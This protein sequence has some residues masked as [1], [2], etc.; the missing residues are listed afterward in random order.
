MRRYGVGEHPRGTVTLLFTDIEGSTHLLQRV[1]ER[2]ADLLQTCRHLLRTTFHQYH[3]H[4]VDTQGDAFFVAFARATDAVLAAVG[5]QRALAVHAW[6]E[7]VTVSAR[8][9]LH[10]GEPLRTAEG[11]V[12]LDIHHASRIMSAGHG[13]QVLLSQT[14]CAM[15]EQSL[16]EGV[17]LRD[18]GEH[19]LKDLQRASHLYQL[20]IV[21]LPADFPPLKTLDASHH[22]LPIQLTPFLG[23][24]QVVATVQ[25]LLLREE[26]RLLT[27][28]GPGGTGKT[29]LGLQVTAE[30]SDRFSDGVHFVNLAPISDPELVVPTIAQTL[31]L[32]GTREQ[33]MLDMLQAYLA[34]EADLAAAGQLR[35]GGQCRRAGGRPAGCLSQA[36][37]AGDESHGAACAR[38][39]GVCRPAIGSTRPETPARTDGIDAV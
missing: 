37:G 19:R 36:Q 35:A 18:L 1:G 16:P 5:M 28:T 11:Y 9:G 15:V 14:T 3:G 8:I 20:V 17:G 26:V 39:A 12:G 34:E 22:N 4:E 38:R 27:L 13:G 29:R 2:Y 31:N 6:P 23:R 33:A 24:E 30:L 10:T 25:D 32:K 7:G 21:G